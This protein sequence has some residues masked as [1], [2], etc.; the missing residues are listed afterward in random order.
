MYDPSKFVSNFVKNHPNSSVGFSKTWSL[1]DKLTLLGVTESYVDTIPYS[2]LALNIA[3]QSTFNVQNIDLNKIMGMANESDFGSWKVSLDKA[4]KGSNF[5]RYT[6]ASDFENFIKNSTNTAE[7]PVV[8]EFEG[9][10]YISE[11]GRHRITIAKCLGLKEIKV[12]VHT[13]TK[14]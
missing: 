5:D 12:K 14:A 7:L 6:T 9:S 10:Y 13:G 11:N 2:D 1:Q 3:Q 4:Q 8:I